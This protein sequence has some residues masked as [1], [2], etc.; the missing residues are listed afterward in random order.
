MERQQQRYS[1]NVNNHNANQLQG[2]TGQIERNR[3]FDQESAVFSRANIL[4]HEDVVIENY[5]EDNVETILESEQ[6]NQEPSVEAG[7]QKIMKSD[8]DTSECE[9][10]KNDIDAEANPPRIQADEG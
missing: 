5:N 1:Q 3:V 6:E 10:M 8:G 4:R 9:E 2:E 7:P